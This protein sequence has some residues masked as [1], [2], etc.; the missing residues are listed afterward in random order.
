MIIFPC[1]AAVSAV[2]RSV[3]STQTHSCHHHTWQYSNDV[4]SDCAFATYII[5]LTNI[6][7]RNLI[8]IF[9]KII[10]NIS[11]AFRDIIISFLNKLLICLEKE[12][13]A[14]MADCLG[15]NLESPINNKGPCASRLTLWAAISSVVK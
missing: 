2:V 15:V 4:S 13:W 5:L 1:R 3:C 12:V 6:T 7:S 11:K 14:P 10:C 9:K 8:K